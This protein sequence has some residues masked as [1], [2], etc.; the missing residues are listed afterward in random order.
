MRAE[1]RLW[2]TADGRLVA[3]GDPDGAVL[4]YAPGDDIASRDE[5]LMPGKGD[6]QEQGEAK[7]ARTP[8]N[9]AR[10]AADDK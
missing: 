9:K 7:Q 5:S 8:A 1:Q 2:R 4:A 3:D 6:G 10:K